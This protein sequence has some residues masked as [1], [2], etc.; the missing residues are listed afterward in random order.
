MLIGLFLFAVEQCYS[1]TLRETN[2]TVVPMKAGIVAVCINLVLNYILIY[3][4][5]RSA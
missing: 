2:E 3:G 1:G 5:V 4:K